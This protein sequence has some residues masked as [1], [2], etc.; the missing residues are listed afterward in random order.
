MDWTGINTMRSLAQSA[1]AAKKAE[2][3][4]DIDM[5]AI[6]I[7]NG[8]DGT[9]EERYG[10]A[11]DFIVQSMVPQGSRGGI[12]NA[13][14]RTVA[15]PPDAMSAFQQGIFGRTRAGILG[16]QQEA[17]SGMS[18]EAPTE[19]SDRRYKDAYSGY[20][21]KGGSQ[22]YREGPLQQAAVLENIRAT[23]I[24]SLKSAGVENPLEDKRVRMLDSKIDRLL[25]S[26]VDSGDTGTEDQGEMPMGYP[27]IGAGIAGNLG[28]L[29]RDYNP[30]ATQGQR[31]GPQG[32][33]GGPITR[34]VAPTASTPTNDPN[35]VTIGITGN[36]VTGGIAPRDIDEFI[37]TVRSMGEK[38]PAA[39][40]MYYDKWASKF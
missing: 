18:F 39:A 2:Q 14:A 21:T 37:A 20:M 30:G 29:A 17:K 34:K 32:P 36:P 4:H 15:P 13:L 35:E 22:Q 6:Q 24:E 19:E 27:S 28:N 12:L 3:L 23:R 1:A 25:G 31:T 7:L 10:K 40:K 33:I 9:P 8:K 5:Q 38:D 16:G 26:N 11:R